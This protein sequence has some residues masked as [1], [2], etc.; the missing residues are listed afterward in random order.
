MSLL[1]PL[2]AADFKQW[3]GPEVV[4]ILSVTNAPATIHNFLSARP[5][6]QEGKIAEKLFD[7]GLLRPFHSLYGQIPRPEDPFEYLCWLFEPPPGLFPGNDIGDDTPK[8]LADWLGDGSDLKQFLDLGDIS[9]TRTYILSLPRPKA[10]QLKARVFWGEHLK[11]FVNTGMR[12]E[13]TVFD[14]LAYMWIAVEEPPSGSIFTRTQVQ[15]NRLQRHLEQPFIGNG[16]EEFGRGLA[17]YKELWQEKK[18]QYYGRIVAIV[19][20][21]G[22]GKTKVTLEHLSKNAGLYICLRGADDSAA[23]GWPLGDRALAQ[24]F[25]RNTHHAPVLVAATVIAALLTQARKTWT[26]INEHNQAWKLRTG[27]RFNSGDPRADN[28]DAVVKIASELLKQHESAFRNATN[29]VGT[30]GDQ[31]RMAVSLACEVPAQA[32]SQ[33][34]PNF[35]VVVDESTDVPS[36]FP[37]G[38]VSPLLRVM[39]CLSH[40]PIWFILA[41]TSSKIM[42]I[43]PSMDVKASQRFLN[44]FSLPPW[45]F[46]PF[47]PFGARPPTTTMVGRCLQLDEIKMHGR[48]LWQVYTDEE[49]IAIASTKL[50]GRPVP[51][52]MPL[53]ENEIFALYSQ[54]IC[55]RLQPSQSSHLIELTAVE[56]HLRLA[57]GIHAGMLMTSCPSEPI[58]ALAAAATIN[59]T[60]TL[61]RH[62]TQALVS[63]VAK[64]CVDRGLEG[65]LYARLVLTLGR[66]SATCDSGGYI[67]GVA[68]NR[69]LRTI[70]LAAMLEKLLKHRAISPS[71][72]SLFQEIGTQVHLNF[73]HFLELNVDVGILD[74]AW[75][76]E[77]FCRG[78]AAQ[79]T[80]CQPVIDGFI[81]GYSG[82]LNRPF[83]ETKIFLLCYQ[84]KA[85]AQAASATLVQ[86]VT[87]PML[88]Y[89]DG[90]LVKPPHAVILIDMATTTKFRTGFQVA[91][92]K[93]AATRPTGN[94]KD[95]TGY[96]AAHGQTEPEAYSI[97][98]RGLEPYA[99][100]EGIDMHKLYASVVPE[101]GLEALFGHSSRASYSTLIN[102]IPQS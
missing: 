18:E 72:L 42:S 54:R 32:L 84:A 64:Y 68:G 78:A 38:Q 67:E 35:C 61:E 99:V 102:C 82:D 28:L 87:C 20:P 48:P 53:R 55:L 2:S 10:E 51:P 49:I 9:A 23:Q 21:S 22:M 89:K 26:T 19:A 36:L 3:L 27:S 5:P 76:F 44:H 66:D 79:C 101:G 70:T 57:T 95:W 16:A 14:R 91:V 13:D 12:G 40:H 37:S 24:F 75:C 63:L 85:R 17:T 41:S 39:G 69:A 60:D 33:L 52:A 86:S 65:E 25:S 45:F 100:F 83:D 74:A 47:E 30:A 8:L 92:S 73:T 15:A 34:I 88:R 43:V 46:L 56:S 50:L 7:G 96:A 62:A 31:A 98:I 1:E 97:T 4:S 81:I 6:P 11:L 29:Q 94:G 93:R 90:T 77:M 80:F 58:L 71:N 59:H